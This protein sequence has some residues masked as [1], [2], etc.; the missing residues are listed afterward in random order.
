MKR[1]LSTTILQDL[2][3][4]I[5]LLSGPR[6]VGKTT[7]S[8]SLHTDYQYLNFDDVSHRVIIR[9]GQWLKNIDLVILDE[10]HKMKDWKRWLKGLYDVKG[11]RPRIIVTGSARLDIAKKM[12]DSLAGRH[13]SFRLHPFCL[14]EL[15]RNSSS[16]ADELQKRLIE[17][18]GFPEPFL[19]DDENFPPRWRRSHLDLILRQDLLDLEQIKQIQSIETLVELLRSRVGS[20]V[21]YSGLAE[22]LGSNPP[23]IKRWITILERLFIIFSLTPWHNNVARSLLKAPKYYFYDTGQVVGD[24]GVKYENFVA[25]SLLKEIHRRQDENGDKIS[26]HYLRNKDGDE[27]DFLISKENRPSL[28]IEAKWSDDSPH[29]ALKKLGSG[30]DDGK[31]EAIQLVGDIQTEKQPEKRYKI[32]SSAKWLSKMDF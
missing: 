22:D 7:L 26:L 6:Q 29:K 23:T 25:T 1:Y 18:G 16:S 2:E 14:K 28:M 15:S 5:V 8:K 30:I 27:V 3:K 9:S 24:I 11:V 19:S 13:F 17:V 4:K 12:G 31:I 32:I 10:L 20:P 21:S